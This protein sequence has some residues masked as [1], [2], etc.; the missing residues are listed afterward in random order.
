MNFEL[1]QHIRHERDRILREQQTARC[2]WCDAPLNHFQV[3]RARKYCD[4][5]CS[6]K[7]WVHNTE[8]GQAWKQRAATKQRARQAA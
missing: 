2:L 4:R 5:V 3:P 8:Q 1:R 6:Q 7:Y